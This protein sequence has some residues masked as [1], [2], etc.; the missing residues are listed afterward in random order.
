M[1]ENR[2]VLNDAKTEVIHV[3]SKFKRTVDLSSVRVGTTN[4]S[5]SI[6][7]RDLGAYFNNRADMRTRVL[8]VCQAAPN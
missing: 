8:K 6:S 2:L 3:R 1:I 7:V 5:T 4:V